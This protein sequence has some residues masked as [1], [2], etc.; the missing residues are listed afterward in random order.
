MPAKQTN[1]KLN[2]L[3]SQV[4]SSHLD[5]QKREVADDFKK[6]LNITN[7]KWHQASKP[8]PIA[9]I[10]TLVAVNHFVRPLI[11]RK[12]LFTTFDSMTTSAIVTLMHSKIT[13]RKLTWVVKND[14]AANILFLST[15]LRKIQIA[16]IDC[17]DFIG[18]SQNYPFGQFPKWQ[19]YLEKGFD[20]AFYPEGATSRNVKNA[21]P[22]FIDLLNFLNS[23]EMGYQILPVSIYFE[24]SSFY[25]NFSNTIKASSD[26]AKDAQQTMLRIANGLPEYLRGAY[27]NQ[28]KARQSK[29]QDLLQQ[30]DDPKPEFAPQKVTLIEN[31]SSK[32]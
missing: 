26:A 27:K 32:K 20:I 29:S 11:L 17:Y 10:P 3:F 21:R 13:K 5:N 30:A 23:Q 12:S 6:I 8:K 19:N 28:L 24:N 16:T 1:D 2:D 25:V 15:K 18:V 4:Y 14:I 7:V 31:P 22:G 9:N